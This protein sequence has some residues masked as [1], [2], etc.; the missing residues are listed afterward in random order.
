MAMGPRLR[1]TAV[2]DNPR[3][4]VKEIADQEELLSQRTTSFSSKLR[5][6]S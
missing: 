6:L 1:K 3:Q 5:S 2:A 4:L